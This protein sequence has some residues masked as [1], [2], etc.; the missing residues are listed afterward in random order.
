MAT[1][2]NRVFSTTELLE[3]VLEGVPPDSLLHAQRVCKRWRTVI[4]ETKSLQ[5]RLFL[6][7]DAQDRA[8][9]KH[10]RKRTVLSGP[11]STKHTLFP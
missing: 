6:R 11:E 5:R 4:Q 1:P 10:N 9:Y 2:T 7:A 3:A 8:I